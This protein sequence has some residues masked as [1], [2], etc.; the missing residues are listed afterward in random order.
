MLKESLQKL[1]KE[2]A[3]LRSAVSDLSTIA[4]GSG[5]DLSFS[6]LN[7]LR[8]IQ[9]GEDEF[10]R[11]DPASCDPAAFREVLGVPAPVAHA[12]STFFRYR[13]QYSGSVEDIHGV[14]PEVVDK[15]KRYF[16]TDEQA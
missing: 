2:V 8:H 4:G 10:E 16:R 14:T 13:R 15:L 5:L 1:T 6:T 7:N 12:L 11:I 9:R 3:A